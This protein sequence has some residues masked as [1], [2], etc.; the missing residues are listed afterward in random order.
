MKFA[1]VL[2]VMLGL[3]VL[4]QTAPAVSEKDNAVM[5]DLADRKTKK[6]IS[7]RSQV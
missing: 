1:I 7:Y 5:N 2:L 3:V 4:S 6:I